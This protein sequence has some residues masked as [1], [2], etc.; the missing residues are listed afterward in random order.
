MNDA[1][2]C[3]QVGSESGLIE[4]MCQD[5][6]LTL[7]QHLERILWSEATKSGNT[8]RYLAEAI[9]AR[10]TEAE[11]KSLAESYSVGVRR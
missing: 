11:R 10:L 6:S 5:G 9:I 4:A 7:L 2:R 8:S 3:E 1:T